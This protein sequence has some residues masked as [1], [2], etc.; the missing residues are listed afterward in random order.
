MKKDDVDFED[1][2]DV[3]DE[4]IEDNENY[5]YMVRNENLIER[6]LNFFPNCEKK[7]AVG[8]NIKKISILLIRYTIFLL[9]KCVGRVAVLENRSLMIFNKFQEVFFAY[10]PQN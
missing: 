2:L 1:D 6:Y 5:Q 3:K 4:M 10:F 8:I 9:C 7:L